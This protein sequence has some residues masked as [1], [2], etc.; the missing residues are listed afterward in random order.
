MKETT[1]K[2]NRSFKAN[3]DLYG[4]LIFLFLHFLLSVNTDM[5]EYSQHKDINIPTWYFYLVFSVDIL[6]VLS[7]ILIALYKKAGV[8]A[9]PFFMVVHFLMHSYFLS[10]FLYSDV[11]VLFF[12]VGLGLLMIIPR[13][14]VFS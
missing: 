13:W 3:I 8:I 6:V 10:T 9:F 11:S 2:P 12:Y 5:A 7:L 14:K 4:V 1:P